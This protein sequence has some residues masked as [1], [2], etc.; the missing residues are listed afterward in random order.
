M[1]GCEPHEVPGR[2]APLPHA[3]VAPSTLSDVGLRRLFTHPPEWQTEMRH[4]RQWGRVTARREAAVLV[5]IVMRN[6]PTVLLTQRTAHLPTHAG[7]IAFP[8]G[9]IDPH[10][11]DAS[12]AALREAEEEIG[13]SREWVEVIGHMPSY[14]TGSG[15]DISPVVAL[16]KAEATWCANPDEVALVFEVPLAFLMDARNHVLHEAQVMGE[17]LHWWSM[18]YAQDARTHYIWGATA[19]MLRNL[20]RL[21]AA[22]Q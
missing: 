11:E 4:E 13:L 17:A 20:Y 14:H 22:A 16:V 19:A 10:D 9:K 5:P 3:K 7:Q 15:F 18:P 6:E 2:A 8:G 21:M 12:A 1:L